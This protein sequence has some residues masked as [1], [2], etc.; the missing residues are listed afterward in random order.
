MVVARNTP[1]PAASRLR[2]IWYRSL[3]LRDDHAIDTIWRKLR[4]LARRLPDRGTDARNA[5]AAALSYIRHR[6]P[7]MRYATRCAA[8]LPIE[9]SRAD[10][11]ECSC[12]RWRD[13]IVAQHANSSGASAWLAFSPLLTRH[14]ALGYAQLG[15]W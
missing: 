2:S 9:F 8:N 10:G 7:K 5:V 13:L 12:R 1:R 3:L 14:H 11:S 4:D 6:K 15:L